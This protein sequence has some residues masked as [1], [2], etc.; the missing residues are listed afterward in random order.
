LAEL[1]FGLGRFD[2]ATRLLESTQ[3]TIPTDPTPTFLLANQYARRNQPMEARKLLL[4]LKGKKEFAENLALAKVLA[5]SF[6]SD[7]PARSQ[8]EID[9]IL[10]A[11]PKDPQGLLLQGRLQFQLMDYDKRRRL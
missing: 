8:I 11:R 3:L 2:D 6:M 5:E 9:Q 10:K 4:E 1:Y 7:E